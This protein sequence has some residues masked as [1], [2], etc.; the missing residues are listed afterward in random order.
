MNDV[1][2]GFA[3]FLAENK[4]REFKRC[5]AWECPLARFYREKEGLPDAVVGG[6][7]FY[8]NKDG[9][10]SDRPLQQWEK[11]FIDFV[12]TGKFSPTGKDCLIYLNSVIGE[13]NGRE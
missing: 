6:V 12:D 2:K 3:E 7:N 9:Y 8:D 13:E 11:K 5:H 1:E 4:D 10:A